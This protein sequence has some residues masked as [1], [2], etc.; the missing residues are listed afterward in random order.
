MQKYSLPEIAVITP[1]GYQKTLSSLLLVLLS[2]FLEKFA[3]TSSPT[4]P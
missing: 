1:G 4:Y 2:E 3:A